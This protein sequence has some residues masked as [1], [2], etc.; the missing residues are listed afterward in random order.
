MSSRPNDNYPLGEDMKISAHRTVALAAAGATALVGALTV[1]A[2]AQADHT[3]TTTTNYGLTARAFGSHAD[4]QPMGVSSTRT[5]MS[6]L[7]CTREAGIHKRNFVAS[8]GGEAGATLHVSGVENK[9]LTYQNKR[10]VGSRGLSMIEEVILGD[11]EGA[12]ITITGLHTRAHAFA[13]K[14]KDTLHAESEYDSV[15]ISANTGTELDTVLNEAD[16]TLGDLLTEIENE[17]NNNL[18]IPGLGEIKLGNKHNRVFKRAGIAKSN[19]VALRATLY[20]EDTMPGGD[21]DIE[22]ILGKSRAFI[23]KDLP[24]G[25]MRGKAVPLHANLIGET[26]NVGRVN[27][28]P[29]P[30]RGTDGKIKETATAGVNLGNA[31]SIEA[32]EL[33]SR[34]FGKQ[35]DNGSARAWTEA[36]VTNFSLGDGELE[37]NG[38]VGRVN[39]KTNRKGQIVRR[40]IAGSTIG[41]LFIGGEEHEFPDPGEPLEIPDLAKLEFFVENP[42]TRGNRVT[43]VR[44]TLLEGSDA[45]SVINLGQAQTYIMRR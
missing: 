30:C 41:E 26:L 19:A 10:R 8:T 25:V 11:P 16:A 5:A 15:G 39:V 35:N 14:R 20:G 18:I 37:I 34:V 44:I 12:N 1:A 28:L 36:R 2:P 22:V 24:A 45:G 27:D 13:V 3:E 31:D 23:F 40:N 42:G 43:A 38:I 32:G 7:G 4:A 6:F 33:T 17:V 21:D 29:L 9:T